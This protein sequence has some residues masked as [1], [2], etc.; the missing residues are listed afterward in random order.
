MVDLD[1]SALLARDRLA[2]IIGDTRPFEVAVTDENNVA[3]D[4]STASEI[5]VEIRNGTAQVA[6][7]TMTG[8]QVTR[9]GGFVVVAPNQIQADALVEGTYT[10]AL[11]AELPA[12]WV[13][14]DPA[15][16]DIRRSGVTR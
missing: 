11:A 8:G 9:V 14:S 16:V 5:V 1:E 7:W 3:E 15:Y 6:R 4:F 2:L 13:E 10:I 12:G